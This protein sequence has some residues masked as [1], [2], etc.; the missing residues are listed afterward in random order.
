MIMKYLTYIIN[1]I[2]SFYF[3]IYYYFFEN[4]NQRKAAYN[5]SSYKSNK[6]YSDHLKQGAAIEGVKYLAQKYCKGRGVDVGASKWSLDGAKPIE[7]NK[8]ENAYNILDEDG[9]LDYVFSSHLLEHLSDPLLAI[10][11]WR[12]KLKPGGI[13]FMYL[14][15]PS[16][17]MWNKKNLRHHVWN[18][19]PYYLEELFN[20]SDFKIEKISYLP[21]GYMSFVCIVKKK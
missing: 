21:D 4:L 20:D 14:P 17:H 12:K 3:D 10:D 15:H 13:L 5:Y 11:E 1:I 6:Y 2:K 7:D 18:P 9:S 16:C 19:D 8:D